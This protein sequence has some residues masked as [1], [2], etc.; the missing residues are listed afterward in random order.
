MALAQLSPEMDFIIGPQVPIGTSY[1]DQT[2]VAKAR[3]HGE[4]CPATPPT[5]DN[6]LNSFILLHYYDLP[7]VLYI[8]YKRTGDVTF[9]ALARKAADAWWKVPTW[10]DEGRKSVNMDDI[11]PSPRHAGIGG[12]ILRALDGRPEMWPWII[13][14]V[15][16]QLNVWCKLRI[17]NDQLWYGPREVAFSMHYAAWI[18]KTLPDS[19]PNAAQIKS[20]F[21]ADL[22]NLAI[23]YTG[24]L[25]YADGSWRDSSEWQDTVLARLTSPAALNATQLQVVPLSF[26]ITANQK[27]AFVNGGITKTTKPQSAGSAVIDIEPLPVARAKDESLYVDDGTMVGSMQPF[28]VGLLTSALVDVH[29]VVTSSIAKES[30]KNQ[31][32]K[33]C[34]H[35][36]SDGPYAKDQIEVNS[37]VRIRGFH[38]FFHGGTTTNPTK[39]AKGD[40]VFPW[41]ATEGWWLPSTRQ[42]ISTIVSP[43]GYA[44]LISGDPFFKTAGDELWDSAYSGTD[45]VRSFIDGTAKNF[46]QHVRRNGSYLVWSGAVVTPPPPPPI[47]GTM[48]ISGAVKRGGVLVAGET[49]TLIDANGT[50]IKTAASTSTG[51][52]FEIGAGQKGTVKGPS[53]FTPASYSF[54][55]TMALT[56]QDFASPKVAWP[57]TEAAQNAVLA[58]QWA[59]RWRLKRNLIGAYCEFEKVD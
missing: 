2:Q 39:Y 15:Q 47:S 42:A 35:L 29:Q 55:G 10:I 38:Y 51:Y 7:L 41:T 3:E 58:E 22:E 12:L 6:G 8:T 32:L 33:A 9:L 5:D 43:F 26:P 23:N 48:S 52:F 56:D 13:N 53:G 11:S 24:R 44:Y 4:A 46:N 30:V 28:I 20:Q 21:I 1:F 34:R 14:Y 31:I 16:I 37:G 54:D 17:N 25:Q 49:V 18:A 19:Y 45:G 50:V 59:A 27:V 36:Y 40:M 57:K